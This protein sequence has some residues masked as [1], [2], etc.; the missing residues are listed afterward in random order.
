MRTSEQKT[1]QPIGRAE[2]ELRL[3][4][5]L[6]IREPRRR[7]SAAQIAAACGCSRTLIWQMERR[8]MA[9]LRRAAAKR[10]S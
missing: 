5:F 4:I 3:E 7:Y 8:A 1:G 10:Q 2:L 6:S 9:K